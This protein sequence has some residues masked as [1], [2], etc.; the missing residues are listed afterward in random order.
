MDKVLL[1]RPLT[2][3]LQQP[4]NHKMPPVLIVFPIHQYRVVYEHR[5]TLFPSVEFTAALAGCR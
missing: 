2:T 4:P 3:V 5:D 1:P